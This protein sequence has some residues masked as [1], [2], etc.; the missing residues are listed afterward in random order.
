MGHL[1]ELDPARTRV[2]LLED[3]TRPAPRLPYAVLSLLTDATLPQ[4]DQPLAANL[5]HQENLRTEELIARYAT[6]AILERVRGYY[7]KRDREMRART[8]SNIPNLAAP[9]C[10][11]PL[12]AYFLRTDPVAGEHLFRDVLAERSFPMGRCWM[13]VI[14]RAAVYYAGPAWEK[15]AVEA[16]QDPAVIVKA[17]AVG[18]LARYGSAASG[19]AVWRAFREWHDWWKDRPAQMNEEN[20]RFEMV[21]GEAIRQARNWTRSGDEAGRMREL[22]IT[23]D[24]RAR[25]DELR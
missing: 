1:Y 5:E 16:L 4:L 21:F 6:G 15:V 18:A 10:E 13:N 19:P 20:R 22:C 8:S 25:A 24:C 3:M 14:G 9:A 12:V 2:L 23:N 7:A 17:D 11:P